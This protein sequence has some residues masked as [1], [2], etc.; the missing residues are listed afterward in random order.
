MEKYFLQL[1]YKMFIVVVQILCAETG[2]KLQWLYQ[3]MKLQNT[4]TI[5]IAHCIQ[6]L[7]L[8]KTIQA[9]YTNTTLKGLAVDAP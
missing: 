5:H 6:K 4:H 9:V 3:C 2:M 8:N 1:L 7:H